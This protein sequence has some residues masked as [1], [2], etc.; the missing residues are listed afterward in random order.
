MG[1][2]SSKSKSTTTNYTTTQ[3][4]G[5]SEIG[6]SALALQGSNNAVSFSDQGAIQAATDIATQSLRQVELA[7]S[8]TRATV[9]EAVK[10]VTESARAETENIVLTAVKWGAIA[11]IGWFG[12]K[13]FKG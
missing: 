12:I 5:F 2:F 7:G 13:A 1:L 6:G 8:N 4:A 9:G 3:N 11:F 10:A